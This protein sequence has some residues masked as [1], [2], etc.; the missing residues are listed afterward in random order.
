MSNR[1]LLSIDEV[2]KYLNLSEEETIDDIDSYRESSCKLSDCVSDSSTKDGS[3]DVQDISEGDEANMESLHCAS[4]LNSDVYR[5]ESI[6]E[7]S[8]SETGDSQ[9]A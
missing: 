2:V 9:I 3:Q 6:S 7:T 8:E 4:G 5:I 1:K